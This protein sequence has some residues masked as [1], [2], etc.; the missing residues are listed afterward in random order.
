VALTIELDRGAVHVATTTR[1]QGDFA[2]DG[3]PD[4]LEARRRA[5]V[6]RPWVWLHQ[7]HGA[8][9]EVVS[10]ATVDRVAGVDADGL[11]TAD[12]D[13]VLAI[14]TADCLPVVLWSPEGVIGAAHAGWRGLDAGVVEATAAAMRGLGAT[15]I[16]ARIGPCIHVECYEFGADD[17]DQV[18][19][20]F[21]DE[22]RGRSA[23][24][25]PAL[26]LPRAFGVAARRAGIGA[27]GSEG[28]CTSCHP[29]RWYSY[30]ARA[31]SGRM[32]TVVWR[33]DPLTELR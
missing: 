21:G 6:D 24:G 5:L 29:D 20:R 13:L 23:S 11:V 30:R 4:A 31:E 12:P 28:S 33:D 8:G 32:A 18:A 1:D 14:Q 26:D 19:A 7:V 25:A 16:E 3:D 27:W 10:R 17:L 15:V 9:V 22:V 2:I